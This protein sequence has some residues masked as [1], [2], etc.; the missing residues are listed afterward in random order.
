[1]SGTDARDQAQ[2]I[3]GRA[4]ARAPE[5]AVGDRVAATAD[6]ARGGGRAAGGLAVTGYGRRG[7]GWVAALVVVVA[8]AAGVAGADAA[9]LFGGSGSPATGSG[10][11]TGTAAVQRGTLT[12]Q[13][14]QNGTLGNAGSYTVIVPS[15][16]GSGLPA[17]GPGSGSGSGSGTYT[18]LPAVGQTIRQGHVLYRVSGNPVVLLYGRVP[19]YR[20]LSE[21]M[22]G[23]DVRQLNTGAGRCPSGRSR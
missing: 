16:S 9:G 14:Q 13:M 15:S 5:Q 10:Y 8:V 7:R 12:E 4:E 18:G 11:K 1:V 21:G 2:V 22:T 19:A 6:P 3:D 20:D 17:P 23:Q